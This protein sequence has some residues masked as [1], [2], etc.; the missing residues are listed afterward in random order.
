M[1]VKPGEGLEIEVRAKVG[2]ETRSF[3]LTSVGEAT[4][5]VETIEKTYSY[6]FK[7]IINVKF[8]LVINRY[9]LVSIF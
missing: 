5:P 6:T 8:V 3:V 1:A 7:K 9:F 2:D 4:Q